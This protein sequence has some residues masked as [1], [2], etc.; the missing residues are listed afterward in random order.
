MDTQMP[1][2]DLG[3]CCLVTVLFGLE[4]TLRGERPHKTCMHDSDNMGAIGVTETLNHCIS[5]CA[6]IIFY[7]DEFS[8]VQVF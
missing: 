7:Y 1:I 6:I 5:W 8:T 4:Y 2:T 3:K